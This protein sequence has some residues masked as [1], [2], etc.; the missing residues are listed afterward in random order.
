MVSVGT[1]N[2][3]LE[4]SIMTLRTQQKQIANDTA[5]ANEVCQSRIVADPTELKDLQGIS[6]VL[7]LDILARII[8]CHGWAVSS[9]NETNIT[10]IY[11]GIMLAQFEKQI[12]NSFDVSVSIPVI[13]MIFFMS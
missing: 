3:L 10:F 4:D 6:Y 8:T 11:D 1:E 5:T 7:Q 13:E 9:C 2:K 12:D